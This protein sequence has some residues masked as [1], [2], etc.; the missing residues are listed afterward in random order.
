[1][2]LLESFKILFA[3]VPRECAPWHHLTLLASRYPVP[4]VGTLTRMRPPVVK[5]QT[6][7]MSGVLPFI[8]FPGSGVVSS[9]LRVLT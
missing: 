5:R 7:I 3:P 6:F 4:A 1:M 2:K 9:R 8:H